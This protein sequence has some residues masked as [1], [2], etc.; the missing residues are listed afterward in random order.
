MKMVPI[1]QI[2]INR[3]LTP[4]DDIRSL[5]KHIHDSGLKMPILVDA[6][7]HLIDGLRRLEALKQ[8]GHTQV[9]VVATAMYPV[10]CEHLRRTRVHGVEA[11]PVTPDRLWELYNDMQ[12][13]LRSTRTHLMTGRSK[14]A[15]KGSAG[16]RPL[17]AKAM[18]FANTGSLQAL[19]QVYRAAENPDHPLHERALVAREMIRN[20]ATTYTALGYMSEKKGLRGTITKS[21]EQRDLLLGAVASI[22]GVVRGLTEMGPLDPKYPKD[23]VLKAV[24]ELAKLRS[25]LSRFLK[26]INEEIQKK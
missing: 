22:R 5:A 26:T 20:G 8:L 13:V 1:D 16:G 19:G 15:A 24:S 7:F 6:D 2:V 21:T 23:E 9:E 12:P 17:F 18:G 11:I 10:A 25:Q 4:G 3:T 14:G